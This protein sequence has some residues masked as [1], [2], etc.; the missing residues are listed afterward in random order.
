[1]PHSD[2]FALKHDVDA[3]IAVPWSGGG[4]ISDPDAKACVVAANAEHVRRIGWPPLSRVKNEDTRHHLASPAS[5]DSCARMVRCCRIELRF[6]RGRSMEP[7]E[8]AD[9]R[10]RWVKPR[11]DSRH[12]ASHRPIIVHGAM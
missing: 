9:R 8:C 2:P 5:A 10:L 7:R 11:V 1:M 3:A 6:P 4:D 12:Q